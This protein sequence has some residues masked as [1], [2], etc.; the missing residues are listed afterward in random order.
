MA[1]KSGQNGYELAG[2]YHPFS[3]GFP[4]A[5]HQ[6]HLRSFP[7]RRGRDDAKKYAWRIKNG[8]DKRKIC[9]KIDALVNNEDTKKCPIL[10]GGRRIS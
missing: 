10:G 9:M 1:A 3:V 4:T 2:L 7:K 6:I 5:Q 8:E